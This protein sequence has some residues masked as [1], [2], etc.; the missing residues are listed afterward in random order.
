MAI[1]GKQSSTLVATME[2][3]SLRTNLVENEYVNLSMKDVYWWP[4]VLSPA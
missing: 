4:T 1:I 3:F 2:V